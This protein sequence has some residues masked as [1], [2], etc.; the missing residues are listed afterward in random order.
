MHAEG[1]SMRDIYLARK[2]IGD[3]ARKTPLVGSPL[4]SETIGA[5]VYL[6]LENLQ[7]TGSFKV[8][9]AANKMSTL[10]EDE[11]ARGVIAVSTGN[12]GRAVAYV[13]SRAGVK[14]L[15]CIP[16]GTRSNK[17][18]GIKA[19]GG[20]VL[21]CG[22]TYDEAEDESVRLEKERG[23]TMINPYDDPY[24]IAGQ[25]TIGLELLDDLPQ[26]DTVLVPVGGGGLISGIA[27]ALKSASDKIRVVGVSM[28]RAPVMYHSLKAGEPIRMEQEDTLADALLGGIGL[29]N[30]YSFRMIQDYVDDFVLVSEK[31]IAKAM[32]FALERHHLLVEGAGALGIAALLARKV[33]G[34]RHNV[35]VVVSGSNVDVPLL[36]QLAQ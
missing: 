18:E 34:P 24:T 7:E 1:I 33:E 36:L 32:V 9:G 16:E 29:E 26:V 13:A 28:D 21:V 15:I 23:L 20:Q 11:K 14:A 30:R 8:R 2:R 35:V 3:L 10:S 19:V 27:L 22:K 17:V 6:K 12:H 4:L 5:S 25:G 31:Q